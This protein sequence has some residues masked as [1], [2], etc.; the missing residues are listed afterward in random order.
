MGI[1][2]AP[3]AVTVGDTSALPTTNELLVDMHPKLMSTYAPLTPLNTILARMEDTG[4]HN[5]SVDWI[6]KSEVPTTMVVATDEAS[7]NTTIYV[8]ANGKT[9]V[10]DTLLYN[11]RNDDIRMVNGDMTTNTLTVVVS[12]GGKT[13]TVWKAGDVIHV[14]PP[15]LEENDE[16]VARYRSVANTRQY[17]LHQI[18]KKMFAITRLEDAMATHFGG[19]GSKRKELQGQKYREY[20]IEKEKLLYFGGRA[21][22]GTAPANRRMA[23]GLNHYLRDGT[24]WK[25]FGGIMTESG[26][27]G[28]VGDY[29]DE[30]PD[31]SEVWVFAAGNV[32][33]IITDFGLN[34]V[35]LNP[36]SK[37]YG[38]D[39]HTYISRGIRANLVACPLL[40]VPVTRGWGWILDMNR[41]KLKTID[42]DTFYPEAL[43]V[44]ESENIYD[45]YRGVYTLM[46]ANEARHAMFVG[47]DL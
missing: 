44:G 40:D 32:L 35:R 2:D 31:A 11:P 8:V 17:N 19:R 37:T 46:V 33:D 1:W 43:N 39:I 5:Y 25:D 7:V 28:F 47:A 16:G 14:L 3:T 15:A 42:K 38:L 20:R 34:K 30:N 36:E 45:T 29:K 6:E 10:D 23:G 12:Q 26:F 22:G 41:I 4:S 18:C 21:T 27:R 24:L 13:S 9:L